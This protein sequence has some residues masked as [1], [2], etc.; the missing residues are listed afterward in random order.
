MPGFYNPEND[1]YCNACERQFIDMM[2]LNQHLFHSLRH[3]W[4][5]ECFRDFRSETAL[6]QVR[7]VQQCHS[8]HYSFGIFVASELPRPSRTRLQMPFLPR[9]VQ[10]SLWSRLAHRIWMP[11]YFPTPSHCRSSVNELRPK[12][13][14]QTNYRACG[15]SYSAH[16]HRH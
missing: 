11:P 9:D 6:F 8:C 5:F 7:R 15:S 2:A 1:P 12:H 3:N 16:L 14:H 4:C 10:E 13:F